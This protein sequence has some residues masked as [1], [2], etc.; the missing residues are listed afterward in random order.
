MGTPTKPITPAVITNGSKLGI[1]EMII[2]LNDLNKKAIN[3]AIKKMANA[4]DI[5]RFFTKYFVPFK[6]RRALP[7]MYT[8]YLSDGNIFATFSKRRASISS[9]RSVFRSFMKVVILAV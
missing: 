4:S 1:S 2:I 9:M 3:K 6:K 8:V 5:I 7:V